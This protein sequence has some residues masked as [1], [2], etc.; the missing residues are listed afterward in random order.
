M[1]PKQSVNIDIAAKQLDRVLSFFPRVEAKASFLFALNSAMLGVLALNV[2]KTDLGLWHHVL[3]ASIAVLLVVASLFFVYRCTFPSLRGGTASLVYFHE[4]AK[5]REAEYLAAF[6]AVLPESL[7][8][9]YLSQ[10]WRNAEILAAKFSD[11]KRAFLLTALAL[12]PW[13]AFLVLASIT[14]A[15]FPVLK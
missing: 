15:Q 6:K 11:L 2:Q 1:V 8:E 13:S 14:H 12:F 10:A 9:D 7:A 3:S 4:I 5:L